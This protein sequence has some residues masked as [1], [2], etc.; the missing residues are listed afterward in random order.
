[1][2]FKFVALFAATEL[3]FRSIIGPLILA[4]M[5]AYLLHPVAALISRV[6]RLSWRWA[7]NLIYLVL[8]LALAGSFTAAGIAI[9]QQAQS[10]I[11]FMQHL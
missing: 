3:Y 10:L 2:G 11:D 8:L 4:F 5:L 6:T 7:V 1:V 9:G